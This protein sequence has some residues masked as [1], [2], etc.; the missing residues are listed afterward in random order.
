MPEGKKPTETGGGEGGEADRPG[1][2]P[3]SWSE[4]HH[5]RSGELG[6]FLTL[7]MMPTD[8]QQAML[9]GS[10]RLCAYCAGIACHAI[11]QVLR[12]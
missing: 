2:A 12:G 4:C 6:T 9:R 3:A 1:I 10:I 11:S 8:E 7:T 5:V